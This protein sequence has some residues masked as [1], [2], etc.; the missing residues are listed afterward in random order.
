MLPQTQAIGLLGASSPEMAVG[1]LTSVPTLGFGAA[2]TSVLPEMAAGAA[3]GGGAKPPLPSST[4][5]LLGNLVGGALGAATSRS[6]ETTSTTSQTRDPWEPAQ[7]WLKDLIGQG[8]QLQQQYQQQPFSSTQQQSLGNVF[9]V[10]NSMN[11]AAPGLLGQ[12]GNLGRGYDRSSPNRTQTGYT[13]QQF[14]L[15][16]LLKMIPNFGG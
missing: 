9:N 8:Q 2:G 10:A 16:S 6:G 3:T 12:M 15:S 14:D 4:G 7:Q 5:N 1:G 11:S 13:P